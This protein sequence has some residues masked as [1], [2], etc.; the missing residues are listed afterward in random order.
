MIAFLI[1]TLLAALSFIVG[2]RMAMAE[3]FGLKL[4]G[5]ILM[6]VSPIFIFLIPAIITTE[7]AP[8]ITR[9][10]ITVTATPVNLDIVRKGKELDCSTREAVE[11]PPWDHEFWFQI[12]MDK[13]QAVIA[14]TTI[15]AG[16]PQLAHRVSRIFLASIRYRDLPV[17][18]NWMSAKIDRKEAF[19]DWFSRRQFRTVCFADGIQAVAII[20]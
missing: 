13:P 14:E 4:I 7:E 5:F 3:R 2:A 20:F 16:K 10:T 1:Q 9:P 19:A 11:T 12:T 8:S 15:V 18:S 6:T 17:F